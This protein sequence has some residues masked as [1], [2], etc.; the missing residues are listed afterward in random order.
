GLRVLWELPRTLKLQVVVAVLRKRRPDLLVAGA[1]ADPGVLGYLKFYLFVL[2]HA[3]P[4]LARALRLFGHRASPPLLLHCIHG[5]DRTGLVCMLLLKL[6]GVSDEAIVRDYVRSELRLRTSRERSEL[7]DLEPR[8]VTDAVIA[9]AAHVAVGTLDYLRQSYGSVY[10]YTRR[11]G[12]QPHELADIRGAL[13][14]RADARSLGE[15]SAPG[16]EE[17]LLAPEHEHDV[18]QASDGIPLARVAAAVA[19]AQRTLSMITPDTAERLGQGPG[20]LERLTTAVQRLASAQ[21][22]AGH[23]FSPGQVME[24]EED[25]GEGEMGARSSFSR[26]SSPVCG[27]AHDQDDRKLRP[28][29]S[30]PVDF[31][32]GAPAA[33]W[34]RRSAT[35]FVPKSPLRWAS[36]GAPRERRA[37]IA[38]PR[39]PLPHSPFEEHRAGDRGSVS[40]RRVP[41]QR[42]SSGEEEGE[43]EGEP[44]TRL[45][46]ALDGEG[47]GEPQTRLKLT[48]DGG[49]SGS[50]PASSEHEA[51]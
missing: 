8:L 3:K 37:A 1:V 10:A 18:C 22:R 14:G 7:S 48:L 2:E 28:W 6:C 42:V 43:G 49:A 39:A 11:I 15:A 34:P 35:R 32:E 9:A 25:G 21:P 40:P 26:P 23:K 41:L 44:P 46:P 5:K 19:D 38:S 36:D 50:V 12:L 4:Q 33:P 29:Q 31:E 20:G 13:M 27:S 47:R 45:T 17:E 51:P 30:L 16:E 24:E